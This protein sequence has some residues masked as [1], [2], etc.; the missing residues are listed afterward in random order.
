MFFFAA[1]FIGAFIAMS[2]L[3]PKP[4]IENAKAAS[5]SDFNFPRAK[6]GDPVPEGFGTWKTKG[7]NAIYLGDFEAVPIT[8]KV[9]T[10]LFS[11]KKQTVG[12]KYY[13]G[14]DLCVAL[15]PCVEFRRMFFGKNEIWNGCIDGCPSEGILAHIDIPDLFGGDDRNGGV[16]G[17]VVFYGGQFDQEVDS[18]LVA[19]IET[20]SDNL[21]PSYNGFAHAVF[22]KFYWGNSPSIEP[23]SFELRRFTNS[24]GLTGGK[25]FMANGLDANAME[26]LH[27]LYVNDWGN[28]DVDPALI[29]TDNWREAAYTIWDEDNGFSAEVAN[30]QQGADVTKQILDQ[31]NAMIYQDPSSGLFKIKLI[32]EDYVVDDLPVFGPSEVVE[33]RNF[34]KILWEATSNRVR[35]KFQDRSQQYKD[36][37]V[38]LAD[39]FANIRFQG[40]V[41]PVDIGMPGVKVAANANR[42]AA[43]ELSNRNVP[44]FQGELTINREAA[45][46]GPGEPFKLVWPEYNIASIVVRIR[47][48]GLGT[49]EDGNIVVTVVQDEF[50]SAQVVYGSPEPSLLTSVD[51]KPKDIVDYKSFELPAFLV[52]AI[53]GVTA[54]DTTLYAI[55]AA[56]PGKHSLGYFALEEQDDGDFEV[57]TDAPYIETATL[58]NPIDKFDGFVDG[59]IPVVTVASAIPLT[60]LEDLAESDVR[61]G[62]HLLY[63]DGEILAYESFTD[64]GDGTYDLEN[65]WRALLDTTYEIH[66]A[67][68]LVYFFDGQEG[69]L[70]DIYAVP[71]SVDSYVL[72]RT[73]RGR[74]AKATAD[75]ITL[76]STVSRS[77]LPLPPDN[78]K[79]ETL[80]ITDQVSIE[81][82]TIVVDWNERNRNDTAIALE[83]DATETQE[84]GVTYDV[85]LYD[86][87]TEVVLDAG[88]SG[89]TDSLLIPIDAPVGLL[90]LR[91]W[92]VKGGNRS[93]TPAIYPILIDSID[94]LEIDGD[95]V[96]IDGGTVEF[97]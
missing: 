15:G 24:L 72:D 19:Q 33:I 49:R 12:Y 65:V 51:Y 93:F 68:A 90:E 63:I 52:N 80:R 31:I 60:V 17:D 28:L 16:K 43:R 48:F 29:D 5:L 84:G 27:Y 89:T 9:K 6:E 96:T 46:L 53:G 81:G 62:H 47:K 87:V 30:A 91:V 10:G 7:P 76:A 8:K 35:V 38:A 57:L 22:R 95:I 1:L 75:T 64:N 42:I 23:V 56:K 54:A 45:A 58:V 20:D 88:I 59:F 40:R 70:E 4:K 32:R 82:D 3:T 50:S 14:L 25:Y 67:D 34:T 13:T 37:V 2:L 78:V 77:F 41:R 73:I 79:V 94:T 97:S 66:I 85:G 92:A 86:G 36:D 55:F 18:Y 69:F 11:S 83:T 39:D 71:G 74:S 44:L 61:T 21:V 26:V